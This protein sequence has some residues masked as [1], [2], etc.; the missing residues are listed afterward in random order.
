MVIS[1]PLPISIHHLRE[2]KGDGEVIASPYESLGNKSV[3]Q[4]PMSEHCLSGLFVILDQEKYSKE[5]SFEERVILYTDVV[6]TE[7]ALGLLKISFC[8]SCAN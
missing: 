3:A 7:W 8:S 1:L 6:P 2:G 4:W 5:L